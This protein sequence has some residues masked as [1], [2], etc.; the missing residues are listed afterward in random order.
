[1]YQ[2]LCDPMN[3]IT[4]P[5]PMS[6]EFSRQEY[7]NGMPFPPPRDLSNPGTEFMSPVSSALQ[8]DYLPA[9]LPGKPHK[10]SRHGETT[11]GNHVI[12]CKSMQQTW[13]VHGRKWK[14]KLNIR[15]KLCN[16][17]YQLSFRNVTP[18]A[19]VQCRGMV[20]TKSKDHFQVYW[21]SLNERA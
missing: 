17:N 3:Y 14:I 4:R 12:I 2:T 11:W 9:E 7:W 16:L 21:R 6:M 18:V 13:A 20:G 15:D 19:T 10:R 5:A 8:A 1:M